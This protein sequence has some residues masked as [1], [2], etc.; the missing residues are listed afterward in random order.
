MTVYTY[1]PA[2]IVIPLFYLAVFFF[3]LAR[4]RFRKRTLV[5][6]PIF[7]LALLPLLSGVLTGKIAGR[8]DRVVGHSLYSKF[9]LFG[10]ALVALLT[11][12]G[13]F[14]PTFLFING[15]RYE[16]VARHAIEGIGLLPWYGLIVVPLGLI[17]LLFFFKS[18][19]RPFVL[20]VTLTLLVLFPVGVIFNT[21]MRPMATR[22]IVGIVPFSLLIAFG[23]YSLLL[24]LKKIRLRT[25]ALIVLVIPL[26]FVVREFGLFYQKYFYQYNL[27]ANDFW[28]WQWGAKEIIDYFITVQDQYDEL[29]LSGAFNQ[30]LIYFSFYDPKGRCKKCLGGGIDHLD[31]NKKQ[32]FA[33]RVEEFDETEGAL[34]ERFKLKKTLYYPSGKKAFY[35]GQF[36][37]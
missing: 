3:F 22:A 20:L 34:K 1:Y 6:L 12:I 30:T 16:Q 2:I 13:H 11:Y 24:L 4:K 17:Y 25:L 18:K 37:Q 27:Y 26:F 9:G 29:Y 33:L 5:S 36:G 32:L 31:S 23:V 28:G 14:D 21:N 8:I 10:K 7:I 35:I 15:A 19:R